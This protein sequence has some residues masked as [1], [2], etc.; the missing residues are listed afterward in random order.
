MIGGDTVDGVY[1][2]KSIAGLKKKKQHL[3]TSVAESGYWVWFEWFFIGLGQILMQ[4]FPD[5]GKKMLMILICIKQETETILGVSVE[6][7]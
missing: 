7:I 6:E 4:N 2:A 5:K 3:F 1:L